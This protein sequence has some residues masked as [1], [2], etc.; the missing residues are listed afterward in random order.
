MSIVRPYYDG[1]I[2]YCQRCF[3]GVVSMQRIEKGDE[4]NTALAADLIEIID[5]SNRVEEEVAEIPPYEEIPMPGVENLYF[6]I[7]DRIARTGKNWIKVDFKWINHRV[8]LDKDG[9]TKGKT[10]CGCIFKIW[11]KDVVEP[12]YQALKAELVDK[13]YFWSNC[14]LCILSLYFT[15]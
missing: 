9:D 15:W 5:T 6:P 3:D 11:T 2:F 12:T 8:Y 1:P 7:W 10:R 13:R 14:Y 4:N